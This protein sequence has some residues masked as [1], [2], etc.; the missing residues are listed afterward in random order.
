MQS[1]TLQAL[2]ADS[3]VYATH[4]KLGLIIIKTQCFLANGMQLYLIKRQLCIFPPQRESRKTSR[5]Q[6]LFYLSFYNCM[7][8]MGSIITF[9]D[10]RFRSAYCCNCPWSYGLLADTGEIQVC[11]TRPGLSG[12]QCGDTYIVE[13]CNC[14][15][16]G[17]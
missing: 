11:L 6:G 1:A 12:F 3:G 9:I 7:S 2:S 17:G 14:L 15:T 5:K 4:N 13:L 10:V 16:E 8:L